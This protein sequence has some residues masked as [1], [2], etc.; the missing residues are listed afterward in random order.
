MLLDREKL[1]INPEDKRT[2]QI[3]EIGKN[4]YPI[5]IIDNYYKD[6]DYVRELA[7]CLG[8][9]PPNIAHAG[10]VASIDLGKSSLCEAIWRRLIP[11]YGGT[12]NTS[13]QPSTSSHDFFI[14]NTPESELLYWQCS[15]RVE[16]CFLTGRIF[17][18]PEEQCQG[19]TGLYR[20]KETGLEEMLLTNIFGE[21]PEGSPT[22]E[23][24]VLQRVKEMGL[25][26][27]F[28]ALEKAGTFKDYPTMIQHIISTVPNK[29]RYMMDG[30]EH[31]ELIKLLEMKYNRLICYPGFLFSTQ[32]FQE[33]WFG[34]T[35]ETQCLTQDFYF[36]WP[37]IFPEA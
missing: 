37:S 10:Y 14:L 1:E 28:E 27:S 21:V 7:L 4:R 31:W 20:H 8:Y 6:P 11:L 9:T 19:G 23:E 22:I 13:M 34:D 18:N 15:P 32:Y 26:K 33:K 12:V 5:L 24:N 36:H 16:S 17:L 2:H 25:M 30:D 29:I 35:I 3:L